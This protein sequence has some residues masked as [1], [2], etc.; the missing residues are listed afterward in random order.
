VVRGGDTG[1]TGK[2]RHHRHGNRQ[3]CGSPARAFAQMATCTCCWLPAA[4]VRSL[5]GTDRAR[6]I[7]YF[8]T[9]L[10]AGGGAVGHRGSDPAR[11]V[12]ICLHN[13]LL[14][15]RRRAQHW[16]SRRR[17]PECPPVGAV[18]VFLPRPARGALGR[19]QG[20][21]RRKGGRG[22]RGRRRDQRSGADVTV[23]STREPSRV[24]RPRG[25]PLTWATARSA[26]RAATA[27]A[28]NSG[29]RRHYSYP[30]VPSASGAGAQHKLGHARFV[31]FAALVLAARRGITAVTVFSQALHH[32]I[33]A[34]R[35]GRTW[36]PVC[37]PLLITRARS[38]VTGWNTTRAPFSISNQTATGM[39]LSGQTTAPWFSTLRPAKTSRA[40][41]L[42]P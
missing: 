21:P 4:I 24:L 12:R 7:T 35:A 19:A 20:H 36:G 33:A 9:S 25:T 40:P 30:V 26:G 37:W 22:R 15:E 41:S 28:P 17:A 29:G 31:I 5:G 42:K 23:L 11:V 27:W 3:A 8:V 1:S 10:F 2:C 6:L 14:E 34:S 32:L 16:R 38:S 13:G 18:H 39:E